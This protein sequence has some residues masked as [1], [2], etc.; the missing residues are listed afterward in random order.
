[1]QSAY[2]ITNPSLEDYLLKICK[3]SCEVEVA[4]NSDNWDLV[5]ILGALYDK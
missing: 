2:E 5:K 4:M 1:M 3:I